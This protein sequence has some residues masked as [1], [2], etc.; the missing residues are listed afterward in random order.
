MLLSEIAG[1]HGNQ[2][3]KGAFVHTMRATKQKKKRTWIWIIASIVILIGAGLSYYLIGISSSLD[4]FTKSDEDSIFSGI[5]ETPVP[6][7]K[8]EGKERVNILLLGADARG[9]EEGQIARS[10]SLLVASLDPVTKK[11]HLFS[12]LRDTYVPIEGHGEGRIN[13][14]LTLGG[15]TLAMQTVG[16]LLGLDIQYF[17][18]T[19]FEGFKALIDKLGGVYIDVE[20]N[21]RYTDNADGNRYDID[22]K[23]GYQLLDGDKALQYVRFR[24]DAL[25]DYTRT[26]RQRTLLKAVAKEMQ[27][28]WNLV[29]L[30]S[31]LDSVEP[32]VEM[33]ISVG[34]MLKL[35]QLGM[36]SSISGSA[37]VPPMELLN[38]TTRGGASVIVVKDEEALHEFV[39]DVL[40]SDENAPVTSDTPEG[41]DEATGSEA[42]ATATPRP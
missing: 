20:K 13:T 22:L 26:E 4:N 29:R 6:V 21:M 40:Q 16:D 14:A 28:A 5:T 9:A 19:D 30:K 36:E 23:K 38:E 25:S 39:Q 32:Y 27:S 42:P 17:V 11:A 33:N 37:Q 8:W 12:V 15:P 3:L 7:P 35:G 2:Q 31:I 1:I 18:Y 10:D 24:H 41:M 34:D